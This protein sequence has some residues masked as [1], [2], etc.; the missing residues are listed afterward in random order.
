MGRQEIRI[1]SARVTSATVL[2]RAYDMSRA[3]RCTK[4]KR[5]RSVEH[6]RRVSKD[7]DRLHSWCNS[8]KNAQTREYNR[9]RRAGRDLRGLRRPVPI[10][11]DNPKS[12]LCEDDVRLIR[13]LEPPKYYQAADDVASKFEVSRS[14]VLGIWRGRYW[15]HV[16]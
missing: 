11:Q 16:A 15:S 3:K 7:S 8:C 5:V 1:N 2:S 10:G 4:C 6:F 12:I 14:T 13:Q 9:K